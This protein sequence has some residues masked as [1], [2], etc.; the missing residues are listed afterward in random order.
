MPRANPARVI[1]T[2]IGSI[3]VTPLRSGEWHI[4]ICFSAKHAETII[5][6]ADAP[7]TLFA[8]HSEG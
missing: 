1:H 4:A 7:A 6:P 3:R 5:I 8:P 2:D